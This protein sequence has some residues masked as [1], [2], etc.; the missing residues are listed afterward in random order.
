[1]I[2]GFRHQSQCSVSC[3]AL[4]ALRNRNYITCF[5]LCRLGRIH[6]SGLVSFQEINFKCLY[7][8]Y[9]HFLDLE[10]TQETAEN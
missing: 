9:S 3:I 5:L 6:R 1:M 8:V 2:P 7:K 10:V 4:S